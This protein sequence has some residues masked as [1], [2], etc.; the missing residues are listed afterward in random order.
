[1]SLLHF[2]YW[3]APQL[4]R[5]GYYPPAQKPEYKRATNSPTPDLY[6]VTGAWVPFDDCSGFQ[7]LISDPTQFALIQIFDL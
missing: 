7:H 6:C 2:A 5:A 3:I 1:M 4:G